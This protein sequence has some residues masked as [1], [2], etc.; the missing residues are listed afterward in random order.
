M[1]SSTDFFKL[2]TENNP[3]D[4]FG[5]PFIGPD[6]VGGHSRAHYIVYSKDPGI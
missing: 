4:I 1:G 2:F 5:R 3:V 6:G